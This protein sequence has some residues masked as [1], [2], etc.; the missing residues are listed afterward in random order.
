MIRVVLKDGT[1]RDLGEA[2]VTLTWEA[3]L[4]TSEVDPGSVEYALDD[5]HALIVIDPNLKTMAGML[6]GMPIMGVALVDD[7]GTGIR[8]ET[9]M[10]LGFANDLGHQLVKETD[11]YAAQVKLASG[12]TKKALERFQALPA[13]LPPPPG[14]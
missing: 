1:Q 8:V 3:P 5:V 13:D 12:N 10:P 2:K 14:T 11:R 7:R 6:G 9:P 4:G